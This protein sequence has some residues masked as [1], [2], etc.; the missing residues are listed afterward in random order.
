VQA[1]PAHLDD[2]TIGITAF[3]RP[4]CLERLVES[5]RLR[6]PTVPILVADNGWLPADLEGWAGVTNVEVE[7]D[8]GLSASRNALIGACETEFM[9]LAEEDFVFTDATDLGGALSVIRDADE[10]AMVGGTLEVGQQVQHYARRFDLVGTTPGERVLRAVPAGGPMQRTH[11]TRWRFCDMV[12]NWGILRTSAA[13]ALP[14]DE[15]LKLG[16]HVDWFWRLML[17]TDWQVAHTPDLVARHD[18]K[19]PGSYRL[20][21]IRAAEYLEVFRQKHGLARFEHVSATE[22]PIESTAPVVVMGVG[23]SGTSIVARI[24][25]ALGFYGGPADEE[26]VE[27]PGIRELNETAWQTREVDLAAGWDYLE[28]LARPWVVKDPRFVHTLDLWMPLWGLYKPTLVWVVR[29]AE[30]VA[31]SYKRRGENY[32]GG[33]TLESLHAMAREQFDEWPWGK[34]RIDYENIAD[35]VSLFD[36]A[37]AGVTRGQSSGPVPPQ[38]TPRLVPPAEYDGEPGGPCVCDSPGQCRRHPAINKVG[39]LWDICRGACLTEARCREYRLAWD[40]QSRGEQMIEPSAA[41]HFNALPAECRHRGEHLRTCGAG[42][43]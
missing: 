34:I 5:I 8:C 31:A 18:R 2:L 17:E 33:Q 25:M 23:H 12:F 29:R 9:L 21:R 32:R 26:F 24:L 43:G 10:L 6:Y 27:H 39:R 3:N 16:E 13:A 42:G 40:E 15:E 36:L 38:A 4:A 11:G 7:R 28:E 35:A 14:W 1:A 37:R 30:D 22:E 20:H 41:V 19:E